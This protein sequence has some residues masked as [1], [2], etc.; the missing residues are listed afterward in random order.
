[1]KTKHLLLALLLAA[2][3]TTQVSAYTLYYFNDA[4]SEGYWTYEEGEGDIYHQGAPYK[5]AVWYWGDN[6]DYEG[7]GLYDGQ[8]TNWMT[9][10]SGRENWHQVNIPDNCKNIRFAWFRQ[11]VSE[12][13]W[14]N[15]SGS[16]SDLYYDGENA[17]YRVTSFSEWEQQGG[18]QS[19]FDIILNVHI[20]DLCYNLDLELNTAEVKKL[21]VEYDWSDNYPTAIVIPQSVEYNDKTFTVTTIGAYAFSSRNLLTSVEMPNTITRIGNGAFDECNNLASIEIPN[22]VTF[23]GDRA[24]YNCSGLTVIN[25]PSNV[26]YIGASAFNGWRAGNLT[27][28]NVASANP[29]YCSVEGVLFDKNKTVLLQ[30]PCKK[31][32]NSYV[33]PSSVTRIMPSAFS[34]CEKLTAVTLPEHLA[35]VEYYTFEGCTGLTSID[36]PAGV[37]TIGSGAFDYCSSLT[38]VTLHKGVKAIEY[39]AFANCEALPSIYLPEGITLIESAAFAGCLNMTALEFPSTLEYL[40]EGVFDG[41]RNLESIKIPGSVLSRF[42]WYKK[43][44]DYGYDEIRFTTIAGEIR[45]E[46]SKLIV[47]YENPMPNLKT[48]EAPA[49]FFDVPEVNWA[50]CPKYLENV[51]VNSG[52]LNDNVF[53]VINRSYKTLKSLDISNTSNTSLADE[54][55][56]DHYNLTSLILPANLTRVSY[57]A[58]AGCKNLKAIDIPASVEEIAQSAFEDCRSI[59]T[60]TFGGKQP[61]TAPGRSARAAESQLRRIGNWAFY[62]AHE[63]QHLEIPEGVEEIGDGA[64]YGCTY[65]EDLVLPSTV[66]SIGDNCFALCSKL[67]MIV[68]SSPEPPT[69]APKTFYDVKRQIPVYV[70]DDCIDAY[71]DNELW[72]E[73]D[74]Q[75]VSNM[76]SALANTSADATRNGKVIRNGQ[77]L[78]LRDGKTYTV[79]GQEVR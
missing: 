68:V 60:I 77:L 62:N 39:D 28:I 32:G 1:M 20:D 76:P 29:S 22:S 18:W 63:L 33:V 48:A 78:I 36:V 30:Y 54:A 52:E 73:F 66:R 72:G 17:Y 21:Y 9:A 69:I 61:S 59:E 35:R 19:K 44:E 71:E 31:T 5:Y 56:K 40:D 47:K 53:G 70:P 37:D 46:D 4:T 43:I 41:C 27:A 34:W 45:E 42:E 24:F 57:M 74:I 26:L 14:N 75:G 6:A 11:D 64:F 3:G 23:I 2:F 8:W 15:N 13:N 67:T 38:S 7:D 58:V 12:P 49:W 25:I 16:S 79:Q 65:L 50:I 51:T 10:V 55:F